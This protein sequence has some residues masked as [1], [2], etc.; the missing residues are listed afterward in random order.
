MDLKQL[1]VVVPLGLEPR[2]YWLWVS[3]S[4]QLRYGT[5]NTLPVN[6]FKQNDYEPTLPCNR[7]YNGFT[8]T[9]CIRFPIGILQGENNHKKPLNYAMFILLDKDRDHP[10]QSMDISQSNAYSHIVTWA[11]LLSYSMVYP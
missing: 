10:Y 9:N 11:T 2:T 6:V 3:C 7:W 8:V 4:N 1:S 5:K